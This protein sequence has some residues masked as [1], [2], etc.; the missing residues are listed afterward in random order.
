[1]KIYKYSNPRN[2]EGYKVEGSTMTLPNLAPSLIE[3]IN[4]SISGDGLPYTS[5]PMYDDSEESGIARIMANHTPLC[6][7][8]DFAS[9]IS[10]NE[11]EK[12]KSD[13]M[14]DEQI[15]GEN[16]NEISDQQDIRLD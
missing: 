9:E 1:M 13:F 2:C 4:A 6:D 10:K 15:S 12:V 3:I 16:Q 8:Y 11:T 14:S 7:K 5:T